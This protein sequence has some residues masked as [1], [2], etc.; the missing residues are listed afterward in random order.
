MSSSPSQRFIN[1]L[2]PGATGARPSGR[3]HKA[4]RGVAQRGQ[5]MVETALSLLVV[6]SIVF[7]TMEFARLTYAYNFVAYAAQEAAR[8][9]CV[10]G[11]TSPV[12]A[13]QESIAKFV[14]SQAVGLIASGLH[15]TATWSPDNNP[16]A[17]VRIEVT[18]HHPGIVG[19]IL[20][21]STTVSSASQMVISQ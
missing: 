6:S 14:E 8:Y 15:V 19:Q 10:R 18:Y 7:G 21:A 11:N 3:A 2:A 12:P 20:P 5:A 13:T 1:R 4:T 17:A 16:G 9:A